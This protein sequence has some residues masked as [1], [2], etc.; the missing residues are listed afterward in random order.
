MADQTPTVLPKPTLQTSTAITPTDHEQIVALAS[1]LCMAIGVL[2]SM[3]RLYV[4]WPLNVLAGKDDIAYTIAILFAIAQTA[5]MV[6]AV[7]KGFGKVES[8]LHEWQVLSNLKV[9]PILV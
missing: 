8:E 3:A 5:I 1:W 6:N 2:L 9:S 7:R 4:R